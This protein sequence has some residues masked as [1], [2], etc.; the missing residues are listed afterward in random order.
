MNNIFEKWQDE[1]N[2]S[3]TTYEDLIKEIKL[4]EEEKRAFEKGLD[5]PFS[6]TPHLLDLIKKDDTNSPLRK[7]FIP[8]YCENSANAS[9]FSNDFLLESQNQVSQ[10]I[11]KRYPYK[12][13]L[14]A[15]EACPAYCRFCTRSRIAGKPQHRTDFSSDLKYLREHPEIYDVVITGGDPFLLQDDYLEK[16]LS[17]LRKI[18]SIKFIRINTRTPVSIPSRI[19]STLVHLLKRHHVIVNIHFE[20]PD[21]LCAKTKNAC[22]S[23]ANEGILLG[24]QT[25]LLKGINDDESILKELFTELLE[26]KVKPYYLYQCDKVHGCEN[27]YLPPKRGAELINRLAPQLPGLAV[28][29]FVV[30]VPGQIGKCCIA[31]YGLVDESEQE[32]IFRNCFYEKEYNYET[33]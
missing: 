20:H 1:L 9:T 27:F 17:E 23:M 28:P 18:N 12:V 19:T 14:I 33:K 22:L 6:I 11:V 3:I 7:Q 13:I 30:D 2:C 31:P 29:K 24:S 16:L 8:R 21:E 15:T 4:T 32:Y 10:S 5:L 26:I 25:V